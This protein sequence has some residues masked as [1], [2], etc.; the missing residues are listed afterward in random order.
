MPTHATTGDSGALP[1]RADLAAMPRRLLHPGRNRSKACVFVVTLAGSPLVIKD[2][3]DRPFWVRNVLGPWQLRREARAY[4]A[5]RGLCGV[6][7]FAGSIDRRA[8]AM[9]LVEGPALRDLRRGDLDEGFFARLERLVGEMH[10]RGV[11]HGDLHHG[12]VL[13]GPGGQPYLVDF[14]TCWFART[15]GRDS[16]GPLFRQARQ[17]DLR[18]VAKLRARFLEAGSPAPPERRGLYRLGAALR[19]LLRGP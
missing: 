11:A 9:E 19:R 18:S 15:P 4:L 16:G 7:R 14:S 10:D 1:T 12:D 5:L 6:P 8:V 13:A 2:V 3:A 17:A